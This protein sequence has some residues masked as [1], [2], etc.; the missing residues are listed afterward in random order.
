MAF[1]FHSTIRKEKGVFKAMV[2]CGLVWG[3]W[4]APLI[5]HGHDFGTDY[6]GA[7]ITGIL[8]LCVYYIY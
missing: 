6:F 8:T 4:Y 2:I 7:P 5:I 1:V 3:I